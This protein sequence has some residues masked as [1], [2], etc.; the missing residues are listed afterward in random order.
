MEIHGFDANFIL[1]AWGNT[2]FV[3][4]P[5][6]LARALGGEGFNDKLWLC[7]ELFMVTLSWDAYTVC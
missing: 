1:D 7:M 5:Q 3:T 2:S 6:F 4:V